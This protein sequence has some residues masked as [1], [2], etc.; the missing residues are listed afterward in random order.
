VTATE[1][2]AT[3]A[4]GGVAAVAGTGLLLDYQAQLAA[5]DLWRTGDFSV[6]TLTTG[7]TEIGRI[8]SVAATSRFPVGGAWRLGPRFTV[9]R[10]TALSDG[11]Q[12]TTYIPSVLLDWT[13]GRWLLQLDTGAELGRREAFL[14][15]AN[16]TFVQT[17]NTSRY[18]VSLSY[19]VTFR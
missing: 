2:G 14:Q 5:A 9:D 17:Q 15:L 4:S 19:R 18:Y 7:N 3:P 6:L 11:S 12:Q 10:L 13:R 16:G 8:D 1:T